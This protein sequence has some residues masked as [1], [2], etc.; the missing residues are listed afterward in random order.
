MRS[1][2]GSRPLRST[3]S[4]A[5]WQPAPRLLAAT[6]LL[7]GLVSLAHAWRTV[8]GVHRGPETPLRYDAVLYTTILRTGQ[9]T[10]VE[11]PFRYRPLTPLLASLVPPPPTWLHNFRQKISDDELL[12]YR[13]ALANAAGVALAAW[14]L[15]LLMIELGF[16]PWECL[17][18]SLL[19][20]GSHYPVYL[21]TAPLADAWAWASLAAGLW[22]LL[23]RRWWLLAVGFAAGLFNKES[24]LLLPM[25]AALLPWS[26]A[27]RMRLL[28]CFVPTLGAYAW[29][30]LT[31]APDG[32]LLAPPGW[33]TAY[34]ESLLTT[35]DWITVPKSLFWSFGAL[36]IPAAVGWTCVRPGSVLA[37]WRLLIV[38]VL[39]SPFVLVKGMGRVWFMAFPFV[40]P[41]ALLGIRSWI[42]RWQL[43]PQSQ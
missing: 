13:F 22:A 23:T 12:A 5:S 37:R 8:D 3:G 9:L 33:H 25:A 42:D 29:F 1:G 16:G 27:E 35:S 6:L 15:L 24:A 19:L 2:T 40:L 41:L 21:G 34:L 30:R 43:A 31:L 39:L 11:A 4:R 38:V 32:A 20:L 36:W 28:L 26:R 10:S 14:F 17:A 18:G 7:F